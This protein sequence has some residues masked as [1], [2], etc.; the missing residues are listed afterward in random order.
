MVMYYAGDA[1][2]D[3]IARDL[4]NLSSGPGPRQDGLPNAL[5]YFVCKI[6]DRL[7]I[8]EAGPTPARCPPDR[9]FK[10]DAAHRGEPDSHPLV[11]RNEDSG[12]VHYVETLL[13]DP[14]D[15]IQRTYCG[16][17]F[18]TAFQQQNRRIFRSLT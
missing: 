15:P 11:V 10:D 3:G 18:R 4:A 14:P 13:G 2:A 6:N 5:E 7:A 12:C 16:W 17:L 9:A 1:M 8:L